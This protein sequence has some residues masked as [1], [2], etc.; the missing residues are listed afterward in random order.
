M[1]PLVVLALAAASLLPDPA[2]AGGFATLSMPAQVPPDIFSRGRSADALLAQVLL[3]RLHHSPGVIDAV[4]GPNTRRA[5]RAFQRQ[6]GLA[7]AGRISAALLKKLVE[8]NSANIVELYEVTE[9]DLEGRFE[10]V[11]SGMAAKAK[12]H[13]GYASAVEAFA[14]KFHMSQ[15]LLRA[16]NPAA[17]FSRAGEQIV[18]A[19]AGEDRLASRV[20]RIEVDR[21]ASAVRAYAPDGALLASYPATIGSSS[22]PSPQGSM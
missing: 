10:A 20:A 3:D 8:L 15:S 11:P 7:A 1:R 2:R 12:G 16:L 13:V 22:F 4:M 18:V 6:T 14:E 19:V 21:P 5:V 17:S 9:Q